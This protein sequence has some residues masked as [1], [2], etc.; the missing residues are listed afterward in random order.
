MPQE[1]VPKLKQELLVKQELMVLKY[2]IIIR[3]KR[4]QTISKLLQLTTNII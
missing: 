1:G 3:I 4:S 2:Y